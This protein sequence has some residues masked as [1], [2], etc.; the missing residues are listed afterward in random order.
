MG[1]IVVGGNSRSVGKTSVVASLISHLPEFS[2]TAIKVTQFGH[3]ICGS[4][5][6]PCGCESGVHSVSFTEERD[7]GSGTDTS[8]FLA[9]GA[10]RSLWV[11]SRQG[12]LAR[13]MARLRKEIA[14]TPYVIVESNSIMGFLK[15]DLYLLVLD[16][17]KEDF[18]E[19]AR[20]FLHR[21]DALLVRD[22]VSDLHPLWRGISLDRF[23]G[24]PRFEVN[25]PSYISGAV[26]DFVRRRITVAA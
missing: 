19:S 12:E 22:P 1:V 11:C 24:K 20:F 7:A 26:V 8:R 3:G 25:P 16:P 9:A 18:K 10:A 23:D 13:A 6:E 17:A 21:A 4:N 14:S 2:W 15:P 5:G